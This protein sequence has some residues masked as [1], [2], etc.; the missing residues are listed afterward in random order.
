MSVF[1]AARFASRG[2]EPNPHIE[3]N[4]QAREFRT[5]ALDVLIRMKLNSYRDKDRVHLRDMIAV[6]LI[7]ATWLDR[8]PET[9][10]VRLQQLLDNP[11][12]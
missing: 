7:D 4:T 11:D 3:P 2:F 8:F 5:V 1:S 9:L 12:G 10:R 6:G